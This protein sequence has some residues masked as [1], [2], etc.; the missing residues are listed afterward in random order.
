MKV[1]DP[2]VKKI[3]KSLKCDEVKESIR[4]YPEEER[5]GKTDIEILRD[6]VAYYLEMYEEEGTRLG[7]DLEEANVI[8]RRTKNFKCTP[9]HISPV[10]FEP[11]YPEWRIQAAKRTI[12]EYNQLKRLTKKLKEEA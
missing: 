4:S 2:K 3:I 10:C 12:E 6:E 5:D 8:K 7:D 9:Y 1:T 11:V